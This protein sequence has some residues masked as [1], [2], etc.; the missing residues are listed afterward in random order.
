MVGKEMGVAPNGSS[1]DPGG[2]GN[3]HLDFINNNRK[4]KILHSSSARTIIRE[5]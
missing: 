1:R 5:T 3:L 2:D 4:V